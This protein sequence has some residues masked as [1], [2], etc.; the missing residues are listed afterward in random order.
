MR[1]EDALDMEIQKKVDKRHLQQFALFAQAA[2]IAEERN[3]PLHVK[4]LPLGHTDLGYETVFPHCPFC[5]AAARIQRW[6]RKYPAALHECRVCGRKYSP[7]ETAQSK[8]MDDDDRDELRELL[9]PTRFR[10]FAKDYVIAHGHTIE[11]AELIVRETETW[12]LRRQETWREKKILWNKKRAYLAEHVFTGVATVP[13]PPC[14]KDEEETP[15]RGHWFNARAF[16]EVLRRCEQH[17]IPVTMMLHD[18]ADN[19]TDRQEFSRK[20]ENPI[21]LLRQWEQEGCTG[22]FSGSYNVPDDL[23]K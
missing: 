5:K 8:R 10:E 18:S 23:V 17:G 16:A 13:P 15:D 2:E 11:E 9:G 4:L 20:I 21:E 12:E 14:F 1:D 22:K 6:Q 7:V 19:K 3:V